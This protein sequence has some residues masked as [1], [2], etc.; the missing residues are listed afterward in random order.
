MLAP[1]V[2]LDNRS[3]FTQA[4][5]LSFNELRNISVFMAIHRLLV[6]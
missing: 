3:L 4:P 1:L 2:V 6:S 5:T